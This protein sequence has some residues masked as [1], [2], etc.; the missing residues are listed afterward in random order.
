MAPQPV[1]F[2]TASYTAR[3]QSAAH[4]HYLADADC[5]AVAERLP[6]ARVFCLR[7]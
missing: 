7:P 1:M 4:I 3:Q 6:G 2:L 5:A